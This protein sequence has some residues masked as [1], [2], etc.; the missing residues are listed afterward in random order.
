MRPIIAILR[1][2]TPP[3][4]GAVADALIGAGITRIE[5]PLNSPDPFSSIEALAR[6]HGENALIGAGTVLTMEEVAHVYR[7][8]GR[9]IV[10]PN[11][12][13]G[14]I[15]AATSLGLESWPGALT[16][17]ECLAAIRWGATG[18]KLFPA[19]T[20][21]PAHLKAMKAVLPPEVPIYAVGGA[22]P[23][24]FADWRAA[25]V[26]GV[27]LGNA[28]YAAGDAPETVAEKARRAVEAWE[29]AA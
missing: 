27:G 19:S 5:V 11:A 14:V 16:P 2:V 7:A 13:K 22:T 17:T 23:E 9:L 28:I 12:D 26:D 1:G 29:A 3:E 4:V 24:T 21:G 8:G 25:G 6:A 18:I 20:G 15:Y 10:S